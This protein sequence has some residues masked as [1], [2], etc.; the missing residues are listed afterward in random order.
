MTHALSDSEAKCKEL[1]EENK[2]LN[3]GIDNAKAEIGDLAT[4]GDNTSYELLK[5]GLPYKAGQRAAYN[6]ALTIIITNL[7]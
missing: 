5:Q 3:D 2:R 4:D 6:H 7:L 1:E